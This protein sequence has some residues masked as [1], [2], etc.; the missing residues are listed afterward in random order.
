MSWRGPK[1]KRQP[2]PRLLMVDS[3]QESMAPKSEAG[4]LQ[5]LKKLVPYAR[6]HLRL[7]VLALITM[8][9]IKSSTISYCTLTS[10]P[11]CVARASLICC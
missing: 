3:A 9:E 8:P 4:D 11:A 1:T 10:A 6:P 5:L 2:G 7:F